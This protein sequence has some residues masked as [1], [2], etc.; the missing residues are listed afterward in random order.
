MALLFNIYL[1]FLSILVNMKA[2]IGFIL[3]F[4]GK[5][6]LL[7]INCYSCFMQAGC[8]LYYCTADS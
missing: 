7:L 6:T 3:H 4:G 5:S 1:R 2:V 8:T